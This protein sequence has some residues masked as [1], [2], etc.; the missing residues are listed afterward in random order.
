MDIVSSWGHPYFFFFTIFE[1]LHSFVACWAGLSFFR[2]S[3]IIYTF[4]MNVG[5]VVKLGLILFTHFQDFSHDNRPF[6]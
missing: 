3:E 4:P 5:I 1:N 6:G 2:I